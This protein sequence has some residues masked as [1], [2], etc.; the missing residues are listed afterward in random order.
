MKTKQFEMELVRHGGVVT[1]E[2]FV[3]SHKYHVLDCTGSQIQLTP[4]E[5]LEVRT[6]IRKNA[7]IS[8]IGQPKKVS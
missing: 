7:F 1:V 4:F 3:D 8:L 2:Y 6:A 5:Q